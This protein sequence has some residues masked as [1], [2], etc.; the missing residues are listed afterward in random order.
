MTPDTEDREF[1]SSPQISFQMEVTPEQHAMLKAW[2]EMVPTLHFMDIC[3]VSATK[4]SDALIEQ[5][6]RKA[7]W[8][9]H[10][11][12]RDRPQHAFSYLLAL[13]E[14]TSDL[15]SPLSDEELEEQVLKDVAS[16]RSFFR[17]GRVIE[18]DEFLVGYLRNLRR[19]PHELL[20]PAYLDLLA[21]ANNKFALRETVAPRFRLKTAQDVVREADRLSIPRQ[22]PVV[23]IT[24]ACLYGNASAKKVMKFKAKASEFVAQ[25]TLSDI[26]VI[27][28][29][30]PLKVEIEDSARRGTAP[31]PR[32]AFITDDSGLQGILKCFEP[33]SVRQSDKG[34]QQEFRTDVTVKFAELLT[35]VEV[36]HDGSQAVG[37]VA[38]QE[39]AE[40]DRICD[41]LFQPPGLRT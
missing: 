13:I 12:E 36:R 31:Y 1:H 29:F 11:R 19:V 22:H 2:S 40:Y 17:N 18:S 9:E 8:I 33:K 37:H 10:L 7:A 39:P 38:N 24:L 3:V 20:Q 34:D 5:N 6:P 32:T 15:R 35:D 41:L 30:L 26:M 23:L 21:A 25:N 27:S 4:L 28:R 14:K 16:L